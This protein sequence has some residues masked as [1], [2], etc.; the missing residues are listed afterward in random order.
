MKLVIGSDHRGFALVNLLVERLQGQGH[1][2]EIVGPHTA[3][4]SDYPVAAHAVAKAVADGDAELG[5]LVCGSA[6]GVCIAAN[7]VPGVRAAIGLD[8]EMAEMARRHNHANVLC[9]SGDRTDGDGAQAIIDAWLA[10]EPEGGRHARRVE[11]MER[12][13]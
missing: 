1:Q 3:D 12:T 10:A 13:G 2:V 4:S 8:P 11:M 5:L 6:N 9:L 7:K